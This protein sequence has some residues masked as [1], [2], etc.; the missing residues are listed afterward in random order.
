MWL[1]SISAG[2]TG[3][4]KK[5]SVYTHACTKPCCE[6]SREIDSEKSQSI[7]RNSVLWEVISCRNETQLQVQFSVEVLPSEPS[8]DQLSI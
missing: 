3:T 5:V 6:A 4:V 8:S 1:R 2:S 7:Q